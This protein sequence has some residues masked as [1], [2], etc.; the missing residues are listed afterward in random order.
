MVG[1][2]AAPAH[3][4]F[5]MEVGQPE[6]CSLGMAVGHLPSPGGQ[7]GRWPVLSW[8]TGGCYATGFARS[9]LECFAFLG[10]CPYPVQ[11]ARE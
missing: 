11:A 2:G 7:C 10:A 3:I 6:G 8:A 1:S 9:S 4:S 5:G